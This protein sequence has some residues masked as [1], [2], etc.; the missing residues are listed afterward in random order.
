MCDLCC[1]I[2]T[3]SHSQS[4]K[5]PIYKQVVICCSQDKIDRYHIEKVLY[6]VFQKKW[7][8]NSNHYN[9]GTPYQN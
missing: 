1:C 4:D 7:R 8:Q 9:Y 6:T 3:Q 2:R 5:F